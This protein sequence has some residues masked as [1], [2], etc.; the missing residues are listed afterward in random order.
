[1]TADREPLHG[2]SHSREPL[3]LLAVDD[4]PANL[5]VLSALLE[6]ENLRVVTAESAEGALALCRAQAFSAILLDIRLRGMD[7]RQIAW[8]IR[9]SELNKDT[10][11][12]FLTGDPDIAETVRREGSPVLVKPYLAGTLVSRVRELLAGAVRTKVRLP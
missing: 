3:P 12:L 8:L 11:I 6:P 10:P 4:Y 7:G 2:S 9:K 5:L 1:M